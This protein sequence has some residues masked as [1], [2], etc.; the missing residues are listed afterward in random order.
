[1]TAFDKSMIFCATVSMILGVVV[2]VINTS[3][4]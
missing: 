3:D 1:M 4:I 2:A